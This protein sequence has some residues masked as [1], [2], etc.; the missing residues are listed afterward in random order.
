[1]ECIICSPMRRAL[2]TAHYSFAH[3]LDNDNGD[4]TSTIPFVACEN[5]RETLNYI[6]DARYPLTHLK[7]HFP[8]VD[9]TNIQHEHDPIRQYYDEIYGSFEEHTAH[10]ESDDDDALE[11]RAR[12]AWGTIEKRPERNMALV[13]HSAFFWHV[14]GRDPEEL[15]VVEYGDRDVEALMMERGFENCE[16]R[17]VAVEFL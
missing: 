10:R 17:S 11:R 8:H 15:G 3:I 14:F 13:G 9:F 2:Q 7:E 4:G 5:W 1:V 16:L 6:C 12:Q